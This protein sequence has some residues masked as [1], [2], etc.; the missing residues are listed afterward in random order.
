[1]QLT[2]RRKFW[3]ALISNRSTDVMQKEQQ[4]E[5]DKEMNFTHKIGITRRQ[6]VAPNLPWASHSNSSRSCHT[7]HK[8]R[9]MF[10]IIQRI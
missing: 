3:I 6:N 10:S 5:K 8:K 9:W 4:E 2:C 1:M 7:I